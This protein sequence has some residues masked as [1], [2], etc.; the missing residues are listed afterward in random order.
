[1]SE[2][3]VPKRCYDYL[4][5]FNTTCLRR[6]IGHSHRAIGHSHIIQRNRSLLSYN[7]INQSINQKR[8]RVT[9]VTNV[10]AR[11]LWSFS[12]LQS[13]ILIVD[14]HCYVRL[15]Q[16][17]IVIISRVVLTLVNNTRNFSISNKSRV[18]CTHNMSRASTVVL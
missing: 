2:R 6:D 14:V 17:F 13:V 3:A 10:T 8:I 11:P 7:S 12:S 15:S 1:L 4:D 9:K 16:Q 5:G 18:S